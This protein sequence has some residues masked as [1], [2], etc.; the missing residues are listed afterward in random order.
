M[1]LLHSRGCTIASHPSLLLLVATPLDKYHYP[2]FR[3]GKQEVSS[4]YEN[5]EE[6]SFAIYDHINSKSLSKFL[7]IHGIVLES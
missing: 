4:Q 5:R 7:P 2:Y 3:E 1:Y 6:F